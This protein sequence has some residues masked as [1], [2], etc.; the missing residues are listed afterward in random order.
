[1]RKQKA[2]TACG[3]AFDAMTNTTR[4]G[5]AGYMGAGKSTCVRFFESERALIINA[6]AEAKSLM[7]RSRQIIDDLRGTFG[8]TVTDDGGSLR[9][10]ELGRIAFQSVESLSAFNGIVHPPIIRHLERIVADCTKPL[11][12][13]DAALMPLWASAESWFDLRIW[14]DAPFDLR[15]KRLKAKRADIDEGELVRRMRL[16]EEIMAVPAADRWVRLPDSDCREYIV[17]ALNRQRTAQDVH[18]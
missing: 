12:I 9:F 8:D 4:I 18:Y 10:D 7:S 1:M 17:N 5:I 6:D 11:C 3:T 16:Q 2:V 13:L 14:I 15:L